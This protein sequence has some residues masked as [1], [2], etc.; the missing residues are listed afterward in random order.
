MGEQHDDEVEHEVLVLEDEDGNEQT[1]VLVAVEVIGDH[2]YA[3]LATEES[4]ADES[5]DM[6]ELDIL[7]Y[8]GD[9]EETDASL[10]AAIEDDETYDEVK[11]FFERW[12]AEQAEA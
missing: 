12:L 2:P 9:D 11:A 4:F 7:R 10:F 6:L 3:L 8:E 1:Y 5:S